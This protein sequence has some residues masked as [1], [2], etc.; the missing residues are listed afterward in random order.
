VREAGEEA[1][2]HRERRWLRDGH[3]VLDE[4]V[5]QVLGLIQRDGACR[6]VAGDVHAKQLGEVTEVLDF[7]PPTKLS[8]D[9]CKPRGIIAGCGNVVHVKCDHGEDMTGAEDVDAG[10]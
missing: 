8:L 5:T 4:D 1:G 6:A 10:I 3:A 9:R 2:V 7:E